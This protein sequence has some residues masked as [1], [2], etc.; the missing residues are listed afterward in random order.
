VI[1]IILTLLVVAVVLGF[2]AL[3]SWLS[4]R[5]TRSDGSDR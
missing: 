4:T 2:V 3:M 1:G 5:G